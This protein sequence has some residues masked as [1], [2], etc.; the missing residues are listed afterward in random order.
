MTPA[1][2]ELIRRSQATHNAIADL[3]GSQQKMLVV[4]DNHDDV[5]L[6]QRTLRDMPVVVDAAYSVREAIP[7][8]EATDYFLVMIDLNM[9]VQGGAALIKWLA[10]RTGFTRRVICTGDPR[11]DELVEALRFGPL[12]LMSKE[13]TPENFLQL[14]HLVNMPHAQ[15]EYASVT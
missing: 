9:P 12:A 5:L 15:P 14:L 3:I 13:F 6:I 7:M 8:I 11:H 2:T 10:D 4:D 1:S